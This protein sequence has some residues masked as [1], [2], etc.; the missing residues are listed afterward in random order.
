VLHWVITRIQ[1][2]KTIIQYRRKG[3][4]NNLFALFS[5]SQIHPF[6]SG[7]RFLPSINSPLPFVFLEAQ[8]FDE[9]PEY[10]VLA[11]QPQSR[12]L[13]VG[14]VV[15]FGHEAFVADLV[16]A[17]GAL[18]LHPAPE[19]VPAQDFH[20]GWPLVVRRLNPWWRQILLL[21]KYHTGFED[22]ME[23]A[24]SLTCVQQIFFVVVL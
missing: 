22:C 3:T 5:I 14:F 21:L 16:A 23:D 11:L 10:A 8:L 18:R 7:V 17:V 2:V 15:V 6:A 24:A 13:R 1:K 9:R 12:L 20:P 4:A 19:I